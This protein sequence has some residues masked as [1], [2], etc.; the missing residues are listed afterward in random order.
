LVLKELKVGG[1]FPADNQILSLQLAAT[2]KTPHQAVSSTMAPP[3][4]LGLPFCP[5]NL[6]TI[7][8]LVLPNNFQP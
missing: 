5:A 1:T 8:S 6:P 7:T 4:S 3:A 2:V